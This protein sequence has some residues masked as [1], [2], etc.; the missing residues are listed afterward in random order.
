LELDRRILAG[1][2]DPFLH[3]IRNCI[4]HGI[5]PT[6]E[7]TR[8]GKSV[9]ALVQVQ[10]G[11][12]R[13][14]RV[15]IRISDDGRG[16]DL[17]QVKRAA[18]KA[19][20]IGDEELA[21]LAPDAIRQLVFKSDVSTSPWITDLSGR[22]LGLA[23]VRESVEKL[24]G[25]VNIESERGKGTRLTLELPASL[26]SFRAVVVGVAGHLFAI[27]STGV[28]RVLRVQPS[29]LTTI[30]NRSVLRLDATAIGLVPL[31]KLFSLSG[32]AREQSQALHAVLLAVA[33]EELA[34]LVDEIVEELDIPVK[35]L[36]EE[37]EAV[38]IALGATLL[39]NGRVA[40]ILD[41]AE[42]LQSASKWLE[43][44]GAVAR[45]QAET[46]ERRASILVAEDS[47]TSRTLLKGI[48]E[49][50][51]FLVTTAVDGADA[52]AKLRSEKFD[53]VVSDVDMPRLNG[54]G[55]TER[56]RA[57]RDLTDLPVV[58]VTSLDSH[59]D[60]ERGIEVGANAYIVKRSF[61]QSNLL[62]VIR[63]LI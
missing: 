11:Y 63:R 15:A 53:L 20:V 41:P 47:I 27:P 62:A 37:L 48:L 21:G 28:R 22:G 2:R 24:G 7:R 17:E 49:S 4:D 6:A 51:G 42:L 5:E 16:I 30:E 46:A 13:A 9:P 19:R 14:G 58:L 3:I 32:P 56:I 23:I 43:S 45:S 57:D 8:A 36:G 29:E 18:S 1:L 60:R 26:A 39:G 59:E 33:G 34:V 61:E 35:S 12:V 52:F 54:F 55:L 10:I 38:R 50:A 31:A 44:G 25:S 40:P